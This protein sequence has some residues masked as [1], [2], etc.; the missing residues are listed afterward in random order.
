DLRRL[1][2]GRATCA[3]YRSYTHDE[4]CL[5]DVALLLEDI[6]PRCGAAPRAWCWYAAGEC[7]LDI[8]Q[9]L[10]RE[11]LERSIDFAR[12]AGATFF[13][14]I[15]ATSPASLTVRGGRVGEAVVL[16]RWLLPHWLRAGV[17][18]PFWTM[19]RSVAALLV[20]CGADE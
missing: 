19:L 4:R 11:R 17:A 8:D 3:I 18:A 20:R 9:G 1:A 10:A 2:V 16:Y 7:V 14:G 15:A 6:E 12:V 13:E 5:D